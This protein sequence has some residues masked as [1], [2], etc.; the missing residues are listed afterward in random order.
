MKSLRLAKS[1]NIERQHFAHIV[2]LTSASSREQRN[3]I[4]SERNPEARRFSARVL[5]GSRRWPGSLAA[6][7]EPLTGGELGAGQVSRRQGG[8]SEVKGIA[9]DRAF[10]SE[11]EAKSRGNGWFGGKGWRRCAMKWP[12]WRGR[13]IK[14]RSL[15]S[16]D[17]R[18]RASL[19]WS[20]PA[21]R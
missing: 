11:V 8:N 13:N 2:E 20:V 9:S 19:V 5:A 10:Q 7:G 14:N 1:G 16:R 3:M 4:D 12:A 18:R 17:Y 15:R 21:C 6:S